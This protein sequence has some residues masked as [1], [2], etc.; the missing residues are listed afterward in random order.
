M[1]EKREMIMIVDDNITNLKIAKNA[2]SDTYDVFTVP[3]A[4]KMFDLLERNKPSIILLDIDMPDMNGYEAI[5]ILK[6]RP[7]TQDIPVIFLTALSDSDSEIEG[8]SLGAIDYIS[9]PFVPPLLSMRV[10]MHLT[11]EAQKQLLESQNKTLDA[12]RIE[13]KNY[14]ENMLAMVEEKTAEV[15]ELQRAILKTVSDL[16]ENRDDVTGGHIGRTQRFLELLVSK[17]RSMGIYRDQIDNWD[18]ELLLQS[19]QLHDVGKIA[20]RDSILLKPGKLTSDEFEEIKKHTTF[21]VKI[22]EK[23]MEG[24]SDSSF[25]KHAKV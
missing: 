3:S 4:N 16:V 19:S 11:V 18:M 2:M 17:L 23:I 14:N 10:K 5:K 9:K 22:V 13:L 1:D 12:Q 15:L 25:L 8:L 20:I 21:G 24:T 7:D 6:S